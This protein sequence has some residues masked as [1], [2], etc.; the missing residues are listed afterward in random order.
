[1][2]FTM[3]GKPPARVTPAD[4]LGSSLRSRPEARL[5]GC[6]SPA[7][8]VVCRRGRCARLVVV[9]VRTRRLEHLY[10]SNQHGYSR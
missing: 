8:L 9:D 4:V 7:A 5:I 6:N 1:V 10:T 2:F 3:V